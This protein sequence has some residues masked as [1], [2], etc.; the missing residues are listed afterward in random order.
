MSKPND[1]IPP[2]VLH[3]YPDREAAGLIAHY[4]RRLRHTIVTDDDLVMQAMPKGLTL[5]QASHFPPLEGVPTPGR[6]QKL[7]RA[8]T[9]FDLVLTHGWGAMDAAMAHTLFKDAMQLPPLI[10]HEFSLGEAEARRL[11]KRRTWYRRIALG[12]SSGLVVPSEKLEEAA[13]VDWQQPLGRVK[14]IA[15]GVDTKLFAKQPKPDG[16]RVIKR[17]GEFWVGTHVDQADAQDLPMLVRAF[18]SL[19]DDWHLIVLGEGAGRAEAE[20]TIDALELNDRVHWVGTT[21]QPEKVMGLLDIFAVAAD[22]GRFPEAGVQAMAAG[23]PLVV[24]DEGE[25]AHTVA[26]ANH[27][28]LFQKGDETALGEKLGG[29]AKDK[30]ARR[31][32]GE[33]N[34]AHAVARFDRDKTIATYRRLYGSAMQIEL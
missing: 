33:A 11:S 18:S 28:W 29:L 3:I 4:G 14:R 6:L 12:K 8:M 5:K 31:S 1:G 22:A 9:P 13:L 19:G 24:P 2:H 10:H 16:F 26:D 25:L 30:A 21:A 27:P 32:V 15:P 23:A 7:A 17:P 20:Q 34:R